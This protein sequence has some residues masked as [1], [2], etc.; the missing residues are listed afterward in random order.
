MVKLKSNPSSIALFPS[1]DTAKKSKNPY[2]G[3]LAI[4]STDDI[5][6]ESATCPVL[7]S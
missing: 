7:N 2:V 5:L 3:V 4:I 1:I 6:I